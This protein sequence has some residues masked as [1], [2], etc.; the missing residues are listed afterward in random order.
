MAQMDRFFLCS[1]QKEPVPMGKKAQKEPVHLCQDSKKERKI[2]M[3]LRKIREQ[4]DEILR[5]KSR[6]VNID[7]ITAEKNQSLIDDM[8]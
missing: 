5:K 3:A 6:E 1:T 4:G 7:D 2:R 8:L